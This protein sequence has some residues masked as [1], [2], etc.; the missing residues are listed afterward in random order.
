MATTHDRLG[1]QSKKL[2]KDLHKMTGIVRNGARKN[3]GKVSAKASNYYEHG[4]GIMHQF[5]CKVVQIIRDRPRRSALI[6]AGVGLMLGGLLL[7]RSILITALILLMSS[8]LF[9]QSATPFAPNPGGNTTNN[10]ASLFPNAT[11]MHPSPI[12]PG[13]VGSP[14]YNRAI[15]LQGQQA[16]G[17]APGGGYGGAVP[18]YNRSYYSPGN[19]LAPNVLNPPGFELATGVNTGA[20]NGSANGTAVVPSSAPNANA[21][22]GNQ[23]ALDSPYV[24]HAWTA[25]DPNAWRMVNANNQ[26]WYWA[27]NNSWMYYQ[28]GAWS[29]YNPATGFDPSNQGTAA[30]NG[31]TAPPAINQGA[32]QGRN[33]L[34]IQAGAGQPTGSAG[35]QAGIGGGA[36]SGQAAVVG[37]VT[38][39]DQAAAVASPTSGG[40]AAA[41][42]SPGASSGSVFI[43][44]VN[45]PRH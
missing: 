40:Q 33:G 3:V 11:Q 19:T 9:A 41:V 1:K 45:G 29:R 36:T 16:A 6:A 35:G 44:T 5:E 39:A 38:S 2:T 22:P 34:P 31:V 15:Q 17:M 20:S 8:M 30:G 12:G 24:T 13:R 25:S 7:R 18:M 10:P 32:V 37:S 26:W 27:P 42:A 28:N 14:A 23:S 21:P 43:G 4:F